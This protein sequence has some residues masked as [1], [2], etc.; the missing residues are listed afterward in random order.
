MNSVSWFCWKCLLLSHRVPSYPP[1]QSHSNALIM[2]KHEPCQQGVELHS[3]IS[4]K[5]G[6]DLKILRHCL[7]IHIHI[8]VHIFIHAFTLYSYSST[9]VLTNVTMCAFL[10]SIT[11]A[12]VLTNFTVCA[13]V[14]S[15][16]SACVLTNFTVSL[17]NHSNSCRNAIWSGSEFYSSNTNH[18]FH[19]VSLH[20]R[21]HK[22][23]YSHRG[24]QHILHAHRMG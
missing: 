22:N 23:K 6:T 15:Q 1:L 11:S 18:L 4:G 13:F 3:S 5:Q 21:Y 2:S 8:F 14:A 19:S 12:C 16:T 10:A 17:K 20:S 7:C 24:Y 9:F